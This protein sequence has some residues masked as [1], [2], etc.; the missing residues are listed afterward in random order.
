M[1]HNCYF[2]NCDVTLACD[3]SF[4]VA[5]KVILD[6]MATSESTLDEML[7]E[8]TEFVSERTKDLFEEDGTVNDDDLVMQNLQLRTKILSLEIENQ[9]LALTMDEKNELIC[10]LTSENEEL[11]MKNSDSGFKLT[12][13]VSENEP[14]TKNS[15][16]KKLKKKEKCKFFESGNCRNKNKCQYRHPELE[17]QSFSCGQCNKGILCSNSHMK[18][19]C[20]HWMQG[21]CRKGD[22]CKFQHVQS[23]YGVNPK[24]K[25][26]T[27]PNSSIWPNHKAGNIYENISPFLGQGQA[28]SMRMTSIPAMFPFP[29]PN[30]QNIQ[31]ANVS[32]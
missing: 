14:N 6:R 30:Y 13:D 25:K 17:C 22:L 2:H 10:K 20:T 12:E 9:K 7:D 23:K 29:P 16:H 5:H 1:F 28:G 26:P 24:K 19:D 18:N 32:Q 8:L 15:A 3:I 4:I 31:N 21:Q 27:L 11:K